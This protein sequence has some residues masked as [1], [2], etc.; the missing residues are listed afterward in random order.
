M[1]EQEVRERAFAMPRGSTHD[2]QE[3]CHDIAAFTLA[4]EPLH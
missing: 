2:A 1:T 3:I 4:I